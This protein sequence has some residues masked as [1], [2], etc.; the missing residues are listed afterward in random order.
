MSLPKILSVG[1]LYC[2]LIFTG[3]PRFPS[4]GTEIF[5][6]GLSAHAGGG[7][8]I[9]AAHL[10]D[11]G[12]DVSLATMLP[13]RPFNAVVEDQIRA[14]QLDLALAEPLPSGS[15][16]QV[17]VAL[18]D[19][20]E[21]AFVSR[22]SGPP[23][24]RITLSQ[25]AAHGFDHLHIG[26]LASAVERPD[27][28]ETARAAGLTIS[29]DCGW[30]DSL[31]AYD[32]EALAGAVDVFLPNAAEAQQLESLG[33]ADRPVGRI[34]VIKQGQRGARAVFDGGTLDAPTSAVSAV[35]T[36]GAGDAFNAGFLSAWLQKAPLAQCLA[37]GNRRGARAI[38]QRGGFAPTSR[39]AER[40][41]EPSGKTAQP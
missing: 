1:R 40:S 34:T 9:T 16:P 11:L 8:F 29:M 13:P 28:L 7:A 39:E 36:T 6:D 37:A 17:T 22:R 19:A 18:V 2:D 20:G 3:M 23:F 33:L 21:R 31:A 14:A 41:P 10:A 12:H 4:L 30:D 5:C 38:Q 35:D 25:M 15:E 26:E 24:P 32:I 27:I